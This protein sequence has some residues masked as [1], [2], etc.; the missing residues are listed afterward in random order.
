MDGSRFV[1]RHVDVSVAALDTIW[2]WRGW[3]STDP[4]DR[5]RDHRSIDVYRDGMPDANQVVGFHQPLTDDLQEAL[6]P[7]EWAV[8]STIAG[9]Q[10]AWRPTLGALR[11]ARRGTFKHRSLPVVRRR[12]APKT[13]RPAQPVRLN[14]VIADVTNVWEGATIRLIATPVRTELQV[15]SPGTF[16]L[17][18]LPTKIQKALRYGAGS[19]RQAADLQLTAAARVLA[20]RVPSHVLIEDLVEQHRQMH[21]ASDRPA[22]HVLRSY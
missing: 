1:V 15:R 21:A 4:S 10:D 22:L 19:M 16:G 13:R 8:A 11:S 5:M 14:C 20:G 3:A 17:G 2:R 18:E 6:G 7:V 12:E 9:A